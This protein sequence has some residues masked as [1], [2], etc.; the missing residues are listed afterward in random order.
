MINSK[1]INFRPYAKKLKDAEPK[2]EKKVIYR[3]KKLKPFVFNNQWIN[4]QL[5]AMFRNW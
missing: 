3:K 1:P 2:P 4:Y 5:S